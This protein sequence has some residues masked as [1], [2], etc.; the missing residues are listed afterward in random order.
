MRNIRL[1]LAYDG[2]GYAGWQTQ[3][4]GLSVQSAVESGIREFTGLPVTVL[5]AGR[6]D[7]GVHALGQVASFRTESPIPCRGFCAGL[8]KFFP[9]DILV[10]DAVEVDL[11]F[12]ALSGAAD[13]EQASVFNAGG[14]GCFTR[15]AG[16]AA[17]EVQLRAGCGGS[18]F[19]HLLDQINPPPWRVEFV[20]EYLVGRTRS[21]A[22]AAMHAFTQD[23]IGL[24]ALRCV[25]DEVG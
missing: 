23:R 5:A 6:T 4:N 2:S 19:Q 11:D 17:V 15:A 22:E 12:H 21:A 10:L 13:V 24:A 25:L 20:A 3:P 18:A 8:Q 9:S 1:T 16:Q 7:A 14:T